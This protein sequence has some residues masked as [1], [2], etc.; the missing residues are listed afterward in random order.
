[1]VL[2]CVSVIGALSLF[3]ISSFVLRIYGFKLILG[4]PVSGFLSTNTA[5][6]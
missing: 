2:F 4:F 1:M 3:R 5:Q 6:S